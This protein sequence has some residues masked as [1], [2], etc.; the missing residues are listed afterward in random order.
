MDEPVNPNKNAVTYGEMV[1]F[2]DDRSLSLIIRDAKNDG[3]KALNILREHYLSRG[4]PK[5]I[6]LYTE[7]TSLRKQPEENITDYMIRAENAATFLKNVG[8]T[9]SDG[10]LVAMILRMKDSRMNTTPSPLW[11]RRKTHLWRSKISKRPWEIL[12][13]RGKMKVTQ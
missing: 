2:L 10:L 7:L 8:E 13:K 4:K 5:V 11:W 6:A 3:S 9:I 12:K 1:Q